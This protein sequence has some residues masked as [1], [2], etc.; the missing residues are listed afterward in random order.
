MII[1]VGDRKRDGS[2]SQV[3]ARGL[4]AET[5]AVTEYDVSTGIFTVERGIDPSLRDETTSVAAEA[6]LSGFEGEEKIRWFVKHRK[7]EQR[8]RSQKIRHVLKH[9]GNLKCE[10]VK[11]CFDFEDTYGEIG[12][13]F[14]HVHHLTSLSSLAKQGER[15]NLSDLAIVCAN[16][17]AMIHRGGQCRPLADLKS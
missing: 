13:G 17:H 4:D 1:C 7:R 11:C 14:A 15:I 2:K 12:R 16:C 6:E 8:L 3:R 10:V 9:K 5:W